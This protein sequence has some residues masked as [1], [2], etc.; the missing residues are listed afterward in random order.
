MAQIKIH[1]HDCSD[2]RK[3]L[4]RIDRE[5]SKPQHQIGAL[6]MKFCFFDEFSEG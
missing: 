6:E 4:R 3:R 1:R 2:L 5:S